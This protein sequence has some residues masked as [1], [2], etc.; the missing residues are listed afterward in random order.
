MEKVIKYNLDVQLNEKLPL[1]PVL[2]DYNVDEIKVEN[3]KIILT[4]SDFGNLLNCDGSEDNYAYV[5]GFAPKKAVVELCV[6][7]NWYLDDL[8]DCEFLVS[9][10]Y[11]RKQF[12]EKN[13][14]KCGGKRTNC[15]KIN[16]FIKIY[17]DYRLQFGYVSV[18]Y[19][20]VNFIFSCNNSS[21]RYVDIELPLYC[22]EVVYT[23]SD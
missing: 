2:H 6:C 5:A 17:K 4:T 18:G 11:G 19:H 9:R 1:L 8:S 22:K 15:Y 16:D 21:M 7:D 10:F 12:K 13:R 23:F 20:W 14:L 3:G